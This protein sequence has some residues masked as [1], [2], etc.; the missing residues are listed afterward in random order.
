MNKNGIKVIYLEENNSL[1]TTVEFLSSDINY[2]VK[3]YFTGESGN[4]QWE[5]EVESVGIWCSWP[6]SRYQNIRV[7]D[8]NGDLIFNK[9]WKYCENSDIVEIE[10]INWCRSYIFENGANPNGIVVGSHNGLGGEWVEAY[11][12]DLIGNTL[13]I[14]PNIVPFHQ[15]VSNYQND[16]RFTFKQVV[17]SENNGFVDF[18]TDNDGS[19]ESSSLIQS[20]ILKN[21]NE[22]SKKTVKSLTPS[23]IF[24]ND[25]QWLHIDAEGYDARIILLIE[26]EYMNNLRFIIWEHIHLSEEEK[27]SLKLKLESI[28]FRIV[29]GKDYNTFAIKDEK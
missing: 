10:F 26:D 29:V 1:K 4:I 14:E 18:F 9:V 3:L 22:S 8:N 25:V 2:P 13:L 12:Q 5:H 6:H 17:I 27:E 28:G 21:H 23:D 11:K 16:N 7:I 20:N 24:N 15:L 19:S